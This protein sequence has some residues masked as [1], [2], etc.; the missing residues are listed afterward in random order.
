MTAGIIP[1]KGK[2][3]RLPG[4]NLLSFC[5]HP[6]VA[7]TIVQS[8]YS[9]LVDKTYVSTDSE[10][11]A[12]VGEKYGAQIIWRDFKEHETTPATV[13]MCHAIRKIKG[14]EPE[15][16]V[17]INLLST[18]PCRL[19]DDIDNMIRLKNKLGTREV[20]VMFPHTEANE[21]EIVGDHLCKCVFYD[22]T[23]KYVTGSGAGSVYD[24][25]YYLEMCAFGDTTEEKV[26]DFTTWEKIQEMKRTGH[27]A[28]R[29]FERIIPYYPVKIWQQP[30]IDY[31]EEFEFLEV[32]ME[33]YILKGKGM[34]IYQEY[35]EANI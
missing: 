30:D 23:G 15:L 32:I 33:H 5:G 14:M 20:T 6:L 4:K 27:I 25:D 11:V 9:T 16:K 12:R 8:K 35:Y 24:A 26:D 21:F 29:A 31:Q 3:I 2:S 10:E 13:P 28:A 22:K 18:A 17:I 34:G 19:P 1:A 7:W